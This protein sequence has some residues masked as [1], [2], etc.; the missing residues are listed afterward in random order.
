MNVC[1]ALQQGRLLQYVAA[2]CD[3]PS[4]RQP[5]CAY[6]DYTVLYD[7]SREEHVKL[8]PPSPLNNV[9]VRIAFPLKS[10]FSDPVLSDARTR[11]QKFI[12]ETF[13]C[14]QE[15]YKCTLAG[16]ALAK[17][18]ENVD[19]CFIGESPGGTGQSLFS[20]HLAAVYSHNHAYIDPNLFH[21]EDELRKQLEQFAHCWIITAQEAPETH[22]HFQ[23]DL[24]KK[25]M[26]ADD[27]AARKPYGFVTRMRRVR[28]LKRFE[29]NKIITFRNVMEANFN[30]IYRRCL[31]WQPLPIFVDDT[32]FGKDYDDPDADGIFKKDP[33]LRAWLESGPAIAVA[34]ELQHGFETH[35]S[36]DECFHMIENYATSGLTEKK[37]REACGLPPPEDVKQ[38]CCLVF[39]FVF[40]SLLGSK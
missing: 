23:Q 26:S 31:V 28:G 10:S 16:I 20:A 18:G 21:N 14:N 19:R 24:F 35:Y 6:Q 1:N 37:V 4:E 13:W 25:L 5:G 15:Y 22:R 17:R 11:T 30:S 36:R 38:S 9:Y 33:S 39:R 2:W 7:V 40:K 3:S 32:N 34:L 29:T 27:L 12:K 8:V